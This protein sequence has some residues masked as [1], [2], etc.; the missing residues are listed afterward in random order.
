MT[1]MFPF[2]P[3]SIAGVSIVAVHGTEPPFSPRSFFSACMAPP[4]Q[5]E[6]F[7]SKKERKE[8]KRKR[9]SAL[10]FNHVFCFIIK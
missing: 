9:K 8:S 4:Q 2:S 10:Y 6:I 7:F 3:P 5:A 1:H